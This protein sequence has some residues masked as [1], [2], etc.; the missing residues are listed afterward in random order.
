MANF[1]KGDGLTFDAL[2]YGGGNNSA[3]NFIQNMNAQFN[4]SVHQDFLPMFQNLAGT[5][6]EAVNVSKGLDQL[7][8]LGYKL[9][10]T[11]NPNAISVLDSLIEMQQANAGMQRWVM[12]CPEIRTLYHNGMISG[13]DG[14]YEDLNPTDVGENHYDYR[15]ATNGIVMERPDGR[16]EAWQFF[17]AE[18]PEEDILPFLDQVDIICTWDNMKATLDLGIDDPTSMHGGKL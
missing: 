4:N 2:I 15:R 14:G 5:V 13:Y 18:T 17:D 16:M 3:Q 8:A 10:G 11:M 1:I 6:F 12:A 7:R 9:T